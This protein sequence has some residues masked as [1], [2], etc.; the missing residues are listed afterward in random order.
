[1]GLRQLK[2]GDRN[3]GLGVWKTVSKALSSETDTETGVRLFDGMV[4]GNLASY[5]QT[6]ERLGA[7]VQQGE[8]HRRL[9]DAFVGCEMEELGVTWKEAEKHCA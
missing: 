8:M 6:F 9:K 1:M 3:L 5:M 2:E 7:E 4:P